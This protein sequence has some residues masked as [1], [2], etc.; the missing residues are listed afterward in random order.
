MSFSLD[1]ERNVGFLV[2]DIARLLRARFDARA[3]GLGLT[4]AQW[5]VLIHLG[6]REGINQKALAEIL[7]L[8]TVTLSRHIDRLEAAGWVERRADPADRRAWLIYLSKTAGPTLDRMEEL[9]VETQAE[10]LGALSPADQERLL[11]MLSAVKS[12]MV[13]LDAPVAAD[14]LAANEAADG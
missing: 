14:C 3:Q 2:H 12:A 8:D 5:R 4:R 1:P 6:P 11:T 13:E 7:E 9:A 10:A